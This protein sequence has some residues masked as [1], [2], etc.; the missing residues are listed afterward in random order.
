[1]KKGFIKRVI[2]FA[3]AG[4]LVVGAQMI[5]PPVQVEAAWAWNEMTSE[6]GYPKVP[7]DQISVVADSGENGDIGQDGPAAHAVD[8]N[9]NSYWHTNWH[10]V[11][12]VT[13]TPDAIDGNNTITLTLEEPV[14]LAGIT[15]LPRQQAAANN[16]GPIKVCR[17][18]VSYDGSAFEAAPVAE[19]NW[20]YPTE[21]WN[22]S[23]AEKEL[24]FSDSVEGV[25]AVKIVVDSA[26]ST[27]SINIFI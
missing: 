4:T 16:N 10:N 27:T 15:Y 13:G 8:G 5:L 26:R 11:N 20:T 21:N 3:L 23:I 19:S 25:K 9:V 24:L 12:P 22:E 1:M 2:S 7:T 6:S 17:V 18:Y 14:D